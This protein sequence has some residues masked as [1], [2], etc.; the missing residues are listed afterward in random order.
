MV[1]KLPLAKIVHAMPGRARLRIAARRGDGV[2][3]ASIATGLLAIPGVSRVETR[4]LTGSVVIEHAEPFARI[5]SAAEQGRLF[6]LADAVSAPSS[7]PA[8]PTDPKLVA[9]V[10]LGAFALWQL[11]EG[12]LLPPA[13][14]LAWYTA[15]LSG[16]LSN[17]SSAEDGE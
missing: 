12:R 4:P 17:G 7:A 1:K 10:G 3:F 2:F 14:T 8:M 13:V 5:T 9:A 6:V 16:L 11:A 15:H